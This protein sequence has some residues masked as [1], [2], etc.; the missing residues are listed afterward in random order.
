MA[1]AYLPPIPNADTTKDWT[2][3]ED[4]TRDVNMQTR[5]LDTLQNCYDALHFPPLGPGWLLADEVGAWLSR[6][7]S[8][9]ELRAFATWNN[10][11]KRYQTVGTQDFF[12]SILQRWGAAFNIPPDSRKFQ[13]IIYHIVKIKVSTLTK[14]NRRRGMPRPALPL[15][16]A[17]APAGPA[18]AQREPEADLEVEFVEADGDLLSSTFVRFLRNDDVEASSACIE[19]IDLAKFLDHVEEE[20]DVDPNALLLRHYYPDIPDLHNRI[21]R[22][23][24]KSLIIEMWR[25]YSHQDRNGPIQVHLESKQD[26]G[27]LPS[28]KRPGSPGRVPDE[29]KR[30][31]AK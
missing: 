23:K 7:L 25:A 24:Q 26:A 14:P 19:T 2:G 13:H 1:H 3:I 18:P 30:Q 21:I 20:C 16:P 31:K 5:A 22:P 12:A 17:A 28:P 8:A 4:W 10:G 6:M 15:V 9:D 29:R 27:T 11:Q